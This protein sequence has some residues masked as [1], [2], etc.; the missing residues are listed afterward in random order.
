MHKVAVKNNDNFDIRLKSRDIKVCPIVMRYKNHKTEI[1]LFK[2]PQ[3]GVQL[4]KGTLE[5]DEGIVD[6]A[7]RELY[8]ESGIK[9]VQKLESLGSWE[10]GYQNQQW[11]L[12]V[13]IGNVLPE[14]W[15]HHTLDDSGHEFEFFWFDLYENCSLPMHEV[16]QSVIK[17][18]RQRFNQAKRNILFHLE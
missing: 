7:L 14:Q 4:V 18:I 3:A 15:S 12:F 16:F 10:S 13:C 8:E 11:R 2:H 1:L 9:S 5:P 17:E 6:A